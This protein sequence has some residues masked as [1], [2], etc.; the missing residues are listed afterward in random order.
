M[1]IHTEVAQRPSV[2]PFW[3]DQRVRG[4]LF[5]VLVLAGLLVFGGFIIYNTAQNLQQRGIASGFGFLW[6][7]AGFDISFS[8]ISY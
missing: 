5:Q 2:T 3:Y 7:T 8:L 6:N 4:T 1:A